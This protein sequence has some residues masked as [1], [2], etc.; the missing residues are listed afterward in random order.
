TAGALD[1]VSRTLLTELE[2]SNPEG[3]I[4][5]GGFAQVRLQEAR[6]EMQLT[7]P[8]NTLLFQNSGPQV[9]VVT[10]GD[11]VSLR[12]VT[13]GRDLGATVEILTGV[14]PEDRIVLNPADSLPD[15]AA[16]AIAEKNEAS[17]QPAK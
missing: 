12:P 8:A 13:L 7:L 4:L 9:A 1:P 3:R 10:G 16:V 14:T 15:G 17:P 2:L 5:A 6:P 11:R